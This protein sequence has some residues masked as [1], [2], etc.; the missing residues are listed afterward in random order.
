MSRRQ[1]APRGSKFRPR[2]WASA[3]NLV[4]LDDLHEDIIT[5]SPPQDLD[6]SR[7]RLGSGGEAAW[8]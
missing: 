4:W 3:D 8:C 2:E 1:R 7:P 6:A 5:G